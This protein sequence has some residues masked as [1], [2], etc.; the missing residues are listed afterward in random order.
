MIF[1]ITPTLNAQDMIPDKNQFSLSKERS[2]L[3]SIVES[4]LLRSC[5]RNSNTSVDRIWSQAFQ[6][7]YAFWDTDDHSRRCLY[8]TDSVYA[9][10]V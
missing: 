9:G 10:D 6:N 5:Y 8:F 1:L 2:W 3:W 4:I 7:W